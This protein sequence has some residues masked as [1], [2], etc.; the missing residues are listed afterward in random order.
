VVEKFPDFVI[1]ICVPKGH[2]GLIDIEYDR[3]RIALIH[4]LCN[5]SQVLCFIAGDEIC[6]FEQK[7]DIE[8]KIDVDLVSDRHIRSGFNVLR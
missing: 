8:E 3:I 6:D 2:D 1:D 4:D 7:S 5:L